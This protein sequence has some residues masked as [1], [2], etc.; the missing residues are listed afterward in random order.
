MKASV[1]KQQTELLALLLAASKDKALFEA[2]LKDILT[3][4]EFVE[5]STRWQV[6]TRLAQGESQRTIA[7]DLKI[8]IATVTRGSHALA[9]G[10]GGFAKMIKKL[11][12]A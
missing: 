1:Q 3:P 6:V 12:I 8:G 10:S 7:K 2:V 9:K 5:I 4:S 11:K